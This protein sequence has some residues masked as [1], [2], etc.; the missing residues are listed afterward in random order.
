MIV[1][2]ILLR[3][4]SSRF[5]RYIQI[6]EMVLVSSPHFEYQSMRSSADSPKNLNLDGLLRLSVW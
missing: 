1:V 3:A 5:S 4:S 2:I 6:D